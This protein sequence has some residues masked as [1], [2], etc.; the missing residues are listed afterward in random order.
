MVRIKGEDSF[1]RIFRP[2]AFWGVLGVPRTG[3]TTTLMLI[4]EAALMHGWVVFSNVMLRRYDPKKPYQGKLGRFVVAELPNYFHVKSFGDIFALLPRFVGRARI[5]MVVDEGMMSDFGGGRTLQS[6]K[7]RSAAAMAAQASKLGISIVIVGHSTKMLATSMRVGGLLTGYIRKTAG[8]GHSAQEIARFEIPNPDVIKFDPD[9]LSHYLMS[10]RKVVPKG[11]AR[12]QEMIM[13][14]DG[15]Y[16]PDKVIYEPNT[17][18]SLSTG[19]Y[20]HPNQNVPFNLDHMLEVLSD[21]LPEDAGEA[22]TIEM[23]NPP[24][25]GKKETQPER[26][27]EDV[28]SGGDDD[29]DGE[30]RTGEIKNTIV[31][32]YKSGLTRPQITERLGRTRRSQVYK[33]TNAVDEGLL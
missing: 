7:P 9:N 26:E 18:A 23:M 27:R 32:L 21:I 1:N 8:K 29:H 15:T 28:K 11:I 30:E 33:Y 24:R 19:T 31:S 22:I 12:S 2:G 6:T 4:A 10:W 16:P 17:P 3:K 5:L 14:S 13:L 20:P 25:I